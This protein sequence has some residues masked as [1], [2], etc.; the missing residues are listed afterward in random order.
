VFLLLLL[1][2]LVAVIAAA[3]AAALSVVAVF[4]GLAVIVYIGIRWALA[5]AAI[6]LDRQGPVAALTRS[7]RVT[8]GNALRMVGLYLLIGLV[9]LPIGLAVGLLSVA[10][11]DVRIGA[12]LGALATLVTAPISAIASTQA[13][14]DLTGRPFD[15]AANPPRPTGRWILVGVLVVL[16]LIGAVIAIPNLGAAA[17]RLSG[18]FSGQRGVVLFGTTANPSNPCRPLDTKTDFA[19]SDTIYIGGY[20]TSSVPA[21][22][23]ATESLYKDG[24][25]LGSGDLTSTDQ[26]SSCFSET[27]PVTN[28]PPGSYRLEVTY[29]GNT[30]ASGEFTVH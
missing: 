20:F 13:Y 26:A 24:A 2:V 10:A 29:Q 5:D 22:Q 11:P 9:T 19:T 21:G 7:R 14:G 16:G 15:A 6:V 8:R 1:V 17:D 27:T 3:G 30:L 4:V 18:E 25:L 28:A 12:V 23:T